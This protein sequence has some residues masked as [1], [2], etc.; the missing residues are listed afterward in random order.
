MSPAA[1]KGQ[2]PTAN[3]CLPG[4]DIKQWLVFINLSL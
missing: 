1:I 4:D 3:Q 2:K